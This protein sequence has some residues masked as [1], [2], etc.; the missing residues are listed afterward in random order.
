[1]GRGISMGAPLFGSAQD[2]IK[3]MK[4]NG[5]LGPMLTGMLGMKP[6]TFQSESDFAKSISVESKVFSIYAVGI[7]KGYRRETRSSIHTVVDFRDAPSITDITA[8]ALGSASASSRS[9]SAPTATTT[10]TGEAALLAN[11][12]SQPNPAGTIIYSRIE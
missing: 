6:V 5:M 11:A 10:A 7:V 12:L 3:T 4:G 1:M 9:P 2:F 8:S